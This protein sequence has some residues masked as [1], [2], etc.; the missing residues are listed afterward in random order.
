MSRSL[1]LPSYDNLPY[2]CLEK[3]YDFSSELTSTLCSEVQKSIFGRSF[4]FRTEAEEF[5]KAGGHESTGCPKVCA[6]GAQI[7]AE[8]IM[9]LMKRRDVSS[10][11]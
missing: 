8:K 2:K 3:Q 4:D 1:N 9:E 5:H 7:A 10:T 11:Q 6:I